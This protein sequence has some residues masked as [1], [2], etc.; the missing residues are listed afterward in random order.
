MTDAVELQLP[1][2]PSAPGEIRG[3]V[4][5]RLAPVVS[6][7]AAGALKLVLTELVTNAIVHGD[8]VI[9]VRARVVE[10]AVRVEV[11]D[12]GS[13]SVPSIREA[14]DDGGWGL[15][16]V[17]ALSRRWGVHEGST[18]VWADLPR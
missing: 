2:S 13:R 11:I 1:P 12:A 16:I 17:E 5:D 6:A 7:G 8:G 4:D 10:D 15:Q 3:W 18:H 14:G 9:T